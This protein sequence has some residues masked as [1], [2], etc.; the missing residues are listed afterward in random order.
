MFFFIIFSNFEF[1][2]IFAKKNLKNKAEQ[3]QEKI[4]SETH[5]R[6]NLPQVAI[7]KNFKVFV[8]KKTIYFFHKPQISNVLRNRTISV[9]FYGKVS[10]FSAFKKI[11]DFFSKNPSIF[12]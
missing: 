6:K 1:F 2:L 7:M 5:C 9:A 4:R 11:Q 12:F 10:T 8:R 3:F